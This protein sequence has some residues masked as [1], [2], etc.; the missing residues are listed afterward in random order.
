M[1]QDLLLKDYQDV[2]EA[3]D[4]MCAKGVRRAP[5]VDQHDNIVGIATVDDL[6]YS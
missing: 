6:V 2:Q 5:I 3:I 4:M 1:S